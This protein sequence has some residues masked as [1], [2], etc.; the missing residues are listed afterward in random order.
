M[1]LDF[2]IFGGVGDLSLRK[3]LPSLYYLYRD[4][5]M[6]SEFR[7]SCVSRAAKSHEEFIGLVKSKLKEFVG[8]DF[9]EVVY[10]DFAN[11]LIYK[12]VDL[13]S[14]EDWVGLADCLNIQADTDRE[15]IYYLSVPPTMFAPVCEQIKSLELNPSF[16]RLVVEKPLGE[17]V[18]SAQEINDLLSRTFDEKQIFRID[19]YLGKPALQKILEI[20]NNYPALERRWNK[21]H[22]KRVNITVS[23]KVG[24]EGR[25]EFLDRAGVLRDMVQNHLMQIL[26]LVAMDLPDEM[27]ADLIRDQKVAAVKR[28]S[29]IDETNVNQLTVK[30]QYIAGELD[31]G[32]VPGYLDEI[33]MKNESAAGTGET[34]VAI[35]AYIENDRWQNVPFYLRTGKRLSERK[36]EVEI[37]LENDQKLF[38]EIQPEIRFRNLSHI[39]DLQINEKLVADDIRVPEAYEFLIHQII[40]G[41]QTYFVRDDEIMASWKWIDAVR[42]GWAT[43][44]QQI[45]NYK[46]GS[47]GPTLD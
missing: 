4:G 43:T 5:N 33:K 26:S 10:A 45:E 23:E 24:V 25:V 35:K 3:L 21:D 41:D 22:I 42:A 11:N 20:R 32:S 6:P 40:K 31:G 44:N 36:A 46:A 19:H 14:D 7:I 2:V 34:F 37:I 29:V 12:K 28:L 1:K 8:D 38:I 30:G 9:D 13:S 39:N 15:I 17:D 18:K 16:S 47:N 27:Q